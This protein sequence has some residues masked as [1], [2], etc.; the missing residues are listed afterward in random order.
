MKPPVLT[1]AG[2]DPSGGAGL[3]QDLK[4]FEALG[5]H[6]MALETLLT[7]QTQRGLRAVHPVPDAFLLE[8]LPALLADLPP[9]ALKTGA[10]GTPHTALLLAPLMPRGTPIVVDPVLGASRGK[11]LGAQGLA[12]VIRDEWLPRCS[13][14][15]PNLGEAAVL[16]G[17]P[18]ESVEQME[19]AAR[20]LGALGA[21]AVLVKGGHLAGQEIV[22]VLWD[23]QTMH[24]F[25][26]SRLGGPAPHGTGCAL[27]AAIT[28]GLAKSLPLHEAVA[29]ARDLVRHAWPKEGLFLEF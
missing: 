25:V 21:E 24:R 9:L 13:L 17:G 16:A 19:E 28:C 11:G 22:D 7:V 23:G 20:S 6:G 2:S 27:S 15:T 14:L 18:V 8:A 12:Q 1:L 10:L 26:G 3:Q 4:V 5:C 29:Q